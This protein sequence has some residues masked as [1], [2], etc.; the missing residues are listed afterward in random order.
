MRYT[1]TQDYFV[2]EVNVQLVAGDVVQDGDTDPDLVAQLV[3][4]GVLEPE[5]RTSS[6][7][8]ADFDKGKGKK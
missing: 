8:L 6:T 2:S 7:S 5:Y 1:V 3:S 4:Q